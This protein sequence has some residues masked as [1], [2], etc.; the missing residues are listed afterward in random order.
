M[1][2]AGTTG[3][4]LFFPEERSRNMN[5]FQNGTTGEGA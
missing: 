2:G 1:D 4:I 5:A 3:A